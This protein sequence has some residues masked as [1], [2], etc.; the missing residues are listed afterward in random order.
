LEPRNRGP[1][2]VARNEQTLLVPDRSQLAGRLEICR[3]S[4]VDLVRTRFSNGA[5]GLIDLGLLLSGPLG[6]FLVELLLEAL[7]RGLGFRIWPVGRA[8]LLLI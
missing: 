5:T 8:S 1:A 4:G 7:D 6:G 2:R 3:Y